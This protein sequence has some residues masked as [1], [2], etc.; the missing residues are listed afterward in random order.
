MTPLVQLDDNQWVN[1]DRVVAVLRTSP[2]GE[3]RTH[4]GQTVPIRSSVE[5]TQ[6]LL[7]FKWSVTTSAPVE[8]VLA[9]LRANGESS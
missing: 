8:R 2:T 6:L 4:E 9:L 7:D 1:P 5:E 3:V